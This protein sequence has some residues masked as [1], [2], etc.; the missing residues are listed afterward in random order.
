[1]KKIIVIALTLASLSL[2]AGLAVAGQFVGNGGSI[3]GCVK[4]GLL[5]VVKAGKRCPRHSTPLPFN[6]VGPR[7]RQGIQGVQGSQGVRGVP[8]PV[9]TTAPSGFTQRGFFDIAGDTD[10]RNLATSIAF[11]LELSASPT[12]VEVPNGVSSPDPTHCPG[13]PQAPSAAP[14][15]LCLYDLS[16][17]SVRQ[18][19]A[20]EYLQVTD[21]NGGLGHASPFGARLFVVPQNPGYSNIDGSWAVTAP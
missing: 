20:G 13:S 12:V 4:N 9:T 2:T 14:G 1:M 19:F 18:L 6:Q 21:A 10:G 15:Y 11:P 7:G 3:Q 8:G 5:E 16:E 17:M